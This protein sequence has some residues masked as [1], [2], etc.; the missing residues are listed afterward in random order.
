MSRPP[1]STGT[2]AQDVA[3]AQQ[4]AAP[5]LNMSAALCFGKLHRLLVPA[6]CC[7]CTVSGPALCSPAAYGPEQDETKFELT[8]NYGKESLAEYGGKE[9]FKGN[10]YAQTAISTTV[11]CASQLAV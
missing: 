5:G 3:I 10:A 2:A 6:A 8:Y 11:S 7:D 9:E 4:Q 1:P